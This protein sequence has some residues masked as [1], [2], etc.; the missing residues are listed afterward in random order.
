MG[1]SEIPVLLQ[2]GSKVV[3]PFF[4]CLQLFRQWQ[5]ADFFSE[6]RYQLFLDLQLGL[7]DVL[8]LFKARLTVVI[9]E[10]NSLRVLDMDLMVLLSQEVILLYFPVG[11]L[12]IVPDPIQEPLNSFSLN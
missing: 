1:L 8:D 2:H 7:L 6:R 12:L 10:L 3:H 5:F 9:D 4:E 11:V